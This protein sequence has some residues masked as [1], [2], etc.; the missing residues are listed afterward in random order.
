MKMSL[1]YT[2]IPS[3]CLLPPLSD[4]EWKKMKATLPSPAPLSLALF[5][6]LISPSTVDETTVTRCNKSRSSSKS[7]SRSSRI[8]SRNSSTSSSR[9]NST[10]STEVTEVAAAKASTEHILFLGNLQVFYERQPYIEP[11]MKLQRESLDQWE[12]IQKHAFG[13]AKKATIEPMTKPKHILL[14]SDE[15][16][17]QVMTKP[18]KKKGFLKKSENRNLKLLICEFYFKTI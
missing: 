14:I 17:I 10:S 4:D 12:A 2:L 5:L 8:S 9:N 15:L 7:S 3:L 11:V 1:A 18:A 16:S 6:S 13:P